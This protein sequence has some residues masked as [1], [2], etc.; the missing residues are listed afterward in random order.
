MY[1]KPLAIYFYEFLQGIIFY[2]TTSTFLWRKNE[3]KVGTM[4]GQWMNRGLERMIVFSY[5]AIQKT[6]HSKVCFGA[7]DDDIDQPRS[8]T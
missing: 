2:S 4:K 8:Q 3:K 6:K 5:D 7:R 1:E